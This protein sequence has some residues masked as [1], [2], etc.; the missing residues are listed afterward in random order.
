MSEQV[1]LT[2]KGLKQDRE[3]FLTNEEMANKYGLKVRDITSA[4]KQVGVSTKPL[5][6]PRFVIVDDLNKTETTT[7]ALVDSLG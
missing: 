5:K 1:K 6:K 3:N 4:L 7:T 2:A